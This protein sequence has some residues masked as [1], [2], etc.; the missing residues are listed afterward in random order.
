MERSGSGRR[1][2][3][4]IEL[5]LVSESVAML[6]LS[7]SVLHAFA[8]WVCTLSKQRKSSTFSSLTTGLIFDRTSSV[9]LPPNVLFRSEVNLLSPLLASSVSSKDRAPLLRAPSLSWLEEGGLQVPSLD[10][11]RVS[12]RNGDFG[13]AGLGT[14]L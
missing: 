7:T 6:V 11:V 1:F 2:L 4:E 3:K 5:A 9:K 13:E 8:G 12:N 10:E 14:Q